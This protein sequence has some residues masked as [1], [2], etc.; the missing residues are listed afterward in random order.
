MFLVHEFSEENIDFWIECEE[1][2][3][4]KE[5][6]KQTEQRARDIYNKYLAAQAWKEVRRFVVDFILYELL[7][8]FESH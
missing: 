8:S 7:L 4:M 6:K 2:R 3:K 5:G 1:F